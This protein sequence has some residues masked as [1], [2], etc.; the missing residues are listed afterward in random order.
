MLKSNYNKII[1]LIS[2]L[3]VLVGI[4]M[5]Y[6]YQYQ[7][8]TNANIEELRDVSTTLY[9]NQI[10]FHETQEQIM[11]YLYKQKDI[12]MTYGKTLEEVLIRVQQK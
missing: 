2:I 3:F 10:T 7:I 6:Q 8:K 11:I 4:N 12:N 5:Y 9:N 1:I